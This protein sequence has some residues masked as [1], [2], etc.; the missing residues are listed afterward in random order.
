MAPNSYQYTT[1]RIHIVM[2]YLNFIWRKGGFNS[3]KKE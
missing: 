3:K 1:L 2:R